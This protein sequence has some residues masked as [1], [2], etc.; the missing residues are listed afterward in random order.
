MTNLI[1]QNSEYFLVQV[2]NSNGAFEVKILV[3]FDKSGPFLDILDRAIKDFKDVTSSKQ[4]EC[5]TTH[6]DKTTG[7]CNQ[8]TG[9][10]ATNS[11]TTPCPCP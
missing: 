4:S 6:D 1:Q 5:T 8:I 3:N 9:I 10:E 7:I 2:H 11:Y